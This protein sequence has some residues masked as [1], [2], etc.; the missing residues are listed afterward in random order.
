MVGNVD[1]GGRN[2]VKT[3]FNALSE[4]IDMVRPGTMY[5]DLGKTISK[6]ATATGCSV[7][8]TYC[9]HGIGSLFHTAPNVPHYAKNK[10]KGVMQV[11][12]IFTI[13]P[14]INEGKWQ[15]QT[16]PDNWTASTIDGLRSAQFE[17]TILVTER[18]EE[19]PRGYELLTMR[20]NE[21]TMV[22]TDDKFQR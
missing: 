6:T 22:W 12:H 18:T 2:V 21:P 20:K 3:A 17:H 16:W 1:A 15:D 14:M 11:G 7:V 5:R 8:R 10:A 19:N 13:E 9:G 4:A